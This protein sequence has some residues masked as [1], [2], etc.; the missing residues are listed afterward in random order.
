MQG[1]G[2]RLTFVWRIDIYDIH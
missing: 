1:S 2:K